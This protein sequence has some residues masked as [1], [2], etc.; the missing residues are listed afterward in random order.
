M[1]KAQMIK[2]RINEKPLFAKKFDLN[3]TLFEV[4]K[5]LENKLSK[6]TKFIC[7]DGT[8]IELEDEK[9][10][11]LNDIIESVNNISVC[12]LKAKEAKG[13]A[14]VQKEAKNP[15]IEKPKVQ[16]PKNEE[17]LVEEDGNDTIQE[18]IEK[19]DETLDLS[20]EPSWLKEETRE[21][22]DDFSYSNYAKNVNKAQIIKNNANQNQNK[23]ISK[24]NYN[25]K[26]KNKN[27]NNYPVKSKNNKSNTKEEKYE[28]DFNFNPPPAAN[29]IYKKKE[30]A[31]PYVPKFKKEDLS[32]F[33]KVGKSGNLT[34]YFYP[35]AKFTDLEELN[36]LTFMVVGE[37]GCGKTTLLN[38]FI[39][40]L[41][42]VEIEDDYR[43]KIILENF[44]RSQAY[45]QTTDV[46]YYN[47]R[48]VGGY[49]PVKII[50]TPGYGDTRGI[51]RD[52]EI[53]AQ[54]KVL[55]HDK[56]S[57]LNA[58]CFVT[59]SSN[60]RLSHSQKYILSSILDL[61]GEDVK[62]IF[63]FM[64][65]F[66]DGG[67]PNIIE[68]LQE[69]D[70][71]FS[72]IIKLYRN[73]NWY[74]KFNNSAIFEDNRRDEFTRMFWKLGMKNFSDFKKKLKTLPKK[75][76]VLSR[77]VLSQRKYLEDKVQIL[78]R[79]LKEGLNKIE[80]IKGI[81]KMV[82]NLKGDL[83][84]SK[85]FTKVIKQPV[86]K[87]IDKDPNYYATTCLT[88]TK[89]CH[90]SCMI[91]DD[92]EKKD[93]AAM[94][95][96]GYCTY[97][98]KKCKWDLHKNRDYYLEDVMEDKVVTLEDLKKRYNY[99]KGQLSVKRQL[100]MGAREEL[101]KLNIECLETQ[102]QMIDSINLLHEIALNKSVFESAEQHIDLLIEVEQAEH[103]PGWQH[104]IHGLNVLKEE[105]RILREIYQGKNQ[106]LN[107]IRQFVEQE[108]N[109]YCDID[110]DQLENDNG[111][112]NE[113][114]CSIF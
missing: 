77:T 94:D 4:R 54:I 108:I 72:K 104:R 90:R 18:E 53:T 109:K 64:L 111:K 20:E 87:K 56:I 15:I 58:V 95:S 33:K 51:E 97:C 55:F 100:Y 34:I 113:S 66:C 82:L 107:Q 69:K 89:T 81:M 39:N 8:E 101:I 9:D 48:S 12:H 112:V 29:K 70:C 63:I 21:E 43:F 3:E 28:E 71:P 5:K 93:C 1:S 52:K 32:K 99:S 86:I 67:K 2:F 96:N 98:P 40:S 78:S 105:K 13:Q 16:A 38:S 45:S 25:N 60:N 85:N 37:T 92:D 19:I 73:T 80:E 57:T 10:F 68:P 49:P 35:S 24:N 83:S 41:L 102:Q 46:T 26:A 17:E 11:S 23:E 42:G 106:D 50:D 65:T 22:E 62:E 6:G 75:S 79:K 59:K 88:C 110:L 14:E 76:L 103:K 84:D 44:E 74:Y 47:I 30:E 61:F 31:M 7:A 91:A 114:S 36:A 27:N